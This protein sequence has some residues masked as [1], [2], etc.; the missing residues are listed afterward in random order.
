MKHAY[1]MHSDYGCQN[2]VSAGLTNR[3]VHIKYSGSTEF[4]VALQ[5]NNPGCD[6]EAAPYPATWDTVYAKDYAKSGNIYIPLSHFN[7]D[8]TRALG[9]A[10]KGFRT[11]TATSFTLVELVS[12]VP[13]SFGAVPAKKATGLLHF[14]CTRPNSIA[15]G[16][17]DG[18]LA[19][20]RSHRRMMLTRITRCPGACA[21]NDADHQRR[22][23]Q[24]H[25]L[26]GRERPSRYHRKL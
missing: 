5:E 2:L 16:I 12:S 21:T 13:S 19:L 10:F 24:G 9:F 20:T 6:W 26:R 11:T 15:F 25:I 1:V 18:K 8:K 17:D 14:A 4:T 3:Y 23:H 22:R 7:I